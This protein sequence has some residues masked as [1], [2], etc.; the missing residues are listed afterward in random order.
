MHRQCKNGFRLIKYPQSITVYSTF[1]GCSF[2]QG[3]ALWR[4]AG[5]RF[6]GL[7]SRTRFVALNVKCSMKI[8]AESLNSACWQWNHFNYGESSNVFFIFYQQ[9]QL[10]KFSLI[11]AQAQAQKDLLGLPSVVI[12]LQTYSVMKWNHG[13][14]SAVVFLINYGWVINSLSLKRQVK[15]F[16]FKMWLHYISFPWFSMFF[17]YPLTV[18]E[19]EFVALLCLGSIV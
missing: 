19:Q 6:V 13:T 2:S 8:I 15:T 11:H 17:L 7:K 18:T 5:S 1:M 9:A 10:N 4:N 12:Q 3:F 14:G 16:F